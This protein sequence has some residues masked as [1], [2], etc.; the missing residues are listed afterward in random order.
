MAQEVGYYE[1]NVVYTEGPFVICN[2]LGNGWRIEAELKGCPCPVYPDMSIDALVKRVFGYSGKW[3]TKEQATEVCDWL[4]SKVWVNE[5]I[6]KDS[7]WIA[8]K[9]ETES[10]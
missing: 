9:N 1:D 10:R 5:I 2:P 3:P 7:N 4:N 6:L 8:L